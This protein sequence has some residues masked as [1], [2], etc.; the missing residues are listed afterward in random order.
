V[1]AVNSAKALKS[2]IRKGVALLD[3]NAPWCGP[4]HCQEP[5]F[6]KLSALYRSRA[7]F[8]TIN[9]DD[10]RD[11]AAKF[12]IQGIPTVIIFKDGTEVQRLVG[13]QGIEN[14]SAVLDAVLKP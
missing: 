2:I 14:L 12:R 8:A 7:R 3:F 13:L 5:I 6:L 10:H 11:L 1:K 4:C 9:I